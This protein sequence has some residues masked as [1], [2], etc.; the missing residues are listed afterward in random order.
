MKKINQP[1][2]SIIIPAHNVGIYLKECVNSIS[3][4]IYQNIEI[5]LIENGSTDETG[6]VCD[7]LALSDKR[8]RVVHMGSVGVSDARNYGIDIS[9]GEYVCFVDADDIVSKDYVQYLVGLVL[10]KEVNIAVATKV[11][12][13]HNNDDI[14]KNEIHYKIIESTGTSEDALEEI[15]L[16]KMTVVSCF[17]KIFKRSFLIKEKIRF[18]SDLFIGEGF[19]FNVLAFTK[20]KTIAFS[21]NPIYFY[22][23]NN[24]NSAMTKFNIKKITNG[25]LAMDYMGKILSSE[26]NRV[27]KS[28]EYAKWHTNFDFLMILLSN[29]NVNRD[30]DLF[31]DL[32]AETKKGRQVSESLPISVKEKIKSECASISPVLSG[33]LFNIL[34]KRKMS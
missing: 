8:V 10:R 12:T 14:Y 27:K 21:N 30:L 24:P 2:V 15:L 22:R 17:S 5:I 7:Q 3:S 28:F 34:R 4:G 23:I 1:L 26:T 32:I 25:L 19:N 31:H 18:I 9:F 6:I 29:D 33:K 13:F 20:S 11:L 16:Y